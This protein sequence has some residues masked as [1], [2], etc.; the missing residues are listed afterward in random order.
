[1]NKEMIELLEQLS[2]LLKK[3]DATIVRSADDNH[4]LVLCIDSEEM[5]LRQEFEEEINA[6]SISNGW[7]KTV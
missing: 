6:T 5:C 4:N 7:H 2:D 3:H 1:M